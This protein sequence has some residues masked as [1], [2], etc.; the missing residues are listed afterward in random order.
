[1]NHS[2]PTAPNPHTA[3]LSAA[4][5]GYYR[6]C[7]N[8]PI[9]TCS[10]VPCAIREDLWAPPRCRPVVAAGRIRSGRSVAGACGVRFLDRPAE[11]DRGSWFFRLRPRL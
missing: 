8:C 9:Y 1:M 5:V 2:R 4:Q 6:Y 3:L 7:Y 11:T 10:P